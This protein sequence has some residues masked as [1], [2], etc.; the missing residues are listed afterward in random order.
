MP[1]SPSWITGGTISMRKLF[2]D[3][4]E[5][6]LKYKPVMRPINRDALRLHHGNGPILVATLSH[7]EPVWFD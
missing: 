6:R 1:W 5:H 7:L 2:W 4:K 3:N